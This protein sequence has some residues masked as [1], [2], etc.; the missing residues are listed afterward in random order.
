MTYVCGRHL[1]NRRTG[2]V[3]A[4]VLAT[5]PL[6]FGSAHYANLDLEVAVLISCTLLCFMTA[7]KENN[8]YRNH[9]LFATYLFAALAVLTKGL[10]GIAFPSMIAGSWIILLWRWN[11]FK[12]IHLMKG[13]LL[14][15]MIVLP[16]YILVQKAN[17]EFLHY[18]FVT[19]HFTRFLSAG[20][21]NNKT[22]FWFYLPIVLAGFF[23]WTIFLIQALSRHLRKVLTDRKKNA[24]SLFLLLW[25]AIIFVF[26]SIPHSKIIGYI[27]PVFPALALLVGQYLSDQW[28]TAQQRG[29]YWALVNFI[30][31]SFILATLL[32]LLPKSGW[33]DVSPAI[34]PYSTVIA[35]TFLAS[36]MGSLLFIKKDKLLPLFLICVSCNVIMLPVLVLGATHLN[37]NS[38]KPLAIYL[39]TTAL[40][41]D[42]VI[43]YFKYYQDVPLYL[44]RRVTIVAD[45]NSP[46]IPYRDNWRREL[47]IGMAFQKTDDWLIN[48]KTFWQRFEG[49]KRVFVLLNENYFGQ[50]K[51][52]AKHY[53]ILGRYNDIMLISN[54]L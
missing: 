26:F 3:S 42:E 22:P 1:F 11:A 6:Y 18:F 36:A 21:F 38:A 28:E 53:F 39:K 35:V 54:K 13:I 14:F 16:W 15:L 23:P 8:P 20:E 37:Q 50:F 17:P 43:T 27:L 12:Q 30:V 41:Q 44:G 40:P 34:A 25:L 2:L 4:I 31:L 52:Q 33:I 46:T 49:K 24:A 48:E 29:I 9:F 10:I 51:A 47:W 7:L 19:Q 5:S 45:W 32:F